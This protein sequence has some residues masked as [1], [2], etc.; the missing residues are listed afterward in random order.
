MDDIDTVNQQQNEPSWDDR[1]NDPLADV[2]L[3]SRDKVSF[4]VS[5]WYFKQ[6]RRVI[7]LA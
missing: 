6:K 1:H 4:R 5:S 3:V 7:R 2:V